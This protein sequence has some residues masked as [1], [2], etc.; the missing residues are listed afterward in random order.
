[1]SEDHTIGFT[2]QPI[3]AKFVHGLI[4][5]LRSYALFIWEIYEASGGWEDFVHSYDTEELAY[6]GAKEFA[7]KR[8]YAPLNIQIV[9]MCKLKIVY[10]GVL[11]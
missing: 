3:E 2:V 11:R 1:M 10:M 7:K 4:T 5:E 9:D 8:R 6:E